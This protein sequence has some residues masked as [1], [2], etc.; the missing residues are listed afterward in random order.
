MERYCQNFEG[1]VEKWDDIVKHMETLP[2]RCV[3]VL[4]QGMN[5]SVHSIASAEAQEEEASSEESSGEWT[6][7]YFR[8]DDMKREDS[9][10]SSS[11]SDYGSDSESD[12]WS[13]V[14]AEGRTSRAQPC[15]TTESPMGPVEVVAKRFRD[16][17]TDVCYEAKRPGSNVRVHLASS[18]AKYLRWL[19]QQPEKMDTG[20]IKRHI[21][22]TTACYNEFVSESLCHIL[23][24]DL[25]AK[26]LTPHLVMAFR[27]LRHDKDGYLIQER[28]SAT[29]V[30][31]LEENPKLT[32]RDMA[33]LYLQVFVTLHVLQHA[34]GFKHHDLHLDNVFLK[35]IDDSMK[36]KGES[37]KNATH[38][39]YELGDAVLTV[40]NCGYIV[41]IGDFGFSSL[42]VFGRR[43]QRMSMH[44]PKSAKWGDWDADLAGKRGYDGQVVMGD[45]PFEEDSW[46]YEHEPTREFLCRLRTAA[47][48]PDGKLTHGKH[49]PA[50]GHVS[51]V[52]PMEV[53]QQ[54]FLQDPLPV[55]DFREAPS[56]AKVLCLTSVEDLSNQPEAKPAKKRKRRRAITEA[57][58]HLH[59]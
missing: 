35:R 17:D 56:D 25:V 42:N 46:R 41:K 51:D 43:I 5:C 29:I 27:A 36:W 10:D 55:S 26:K 15:V 58:R 23:L 18:S 39:S 40:P 12:E 8:L 11:D 21:S 49:R 53:L 47:Q 3:S 9:D 6:E 19:T 45:M 50:L 38:F 57:C 30:E 1:E 48:G 22:P 7:D 2:F 32:C 33:S 37:L 59:V 52:T 20:I 13:S 44:T 28:I 34:C 54:V 16:V 31:E 24:T 4:G 14:D